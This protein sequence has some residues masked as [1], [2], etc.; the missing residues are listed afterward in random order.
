MTNDKVL[1]K[2]TSDN[3]IVTVTTYEINSVLLDR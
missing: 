2:V 3:F 1:F